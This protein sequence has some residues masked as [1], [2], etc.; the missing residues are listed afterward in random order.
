TP[1]EPIKLEGAG[2]LYLRRNRPCKTRTICHITSP[3]AQTVQCNTGRNTLQMGNGVN[4][5]KATLIVVHTHGSIV[6]ATG[7]K[8]A[9]AA[10]TSDL[11]S[12]TLM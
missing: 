5:Q 8:N 2:P 10:M 11:K 12:S 9:A 7:Q 6:D 4:P 3:A 1:A